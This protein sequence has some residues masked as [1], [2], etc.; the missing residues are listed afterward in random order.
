MLFQPQFLDGELPDNFES[1]GSHFFEIVDCYGGSSHLATGNNWDISLI[2]MIFFDISSYL[3]NQN[4][5]TSSAKVL[6][7]E[8]KRIDPNDKT[9]AHFQRDQSPKRG[10]WA[11]PR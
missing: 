9:S 2:P 5:F 1:V 4:G 8:E 3:E 6:R 10:Q 11:G 7:Q